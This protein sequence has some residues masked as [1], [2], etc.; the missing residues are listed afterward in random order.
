MNC[1]LGMTQGYKGQGGK[2]ILKL[3]SNAKTAINVYIDQKEVQNGQR[4]EDLDILIG[5]VG[6]KVLPLAP[7]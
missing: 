1:F 4:N 5:V 7:Q 2:E 6:P 3:K